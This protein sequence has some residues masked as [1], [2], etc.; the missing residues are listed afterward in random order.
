MRRVGRSHFAST[1]V[2]PSAIEANLRRP[3]QRFA[4]TKQLFLYLMFCNED[5]SI[6][7]IKLLLKLHLVFRFLYNIHLRR[8]RDLVDAASGLPYLDLRPS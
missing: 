2:L 7:I 1:Q 8:L 5:S 4:S 3:R 6:T